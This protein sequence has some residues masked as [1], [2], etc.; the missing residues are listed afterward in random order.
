M[1]VKPQPHQVAA[2]I[3]DADVEQRIVMMV[4]PVQ[5]EQQRT[6]RCG[7]KSQ[8]LHV[9]LYQLKIFHAVEKREAAQAEGKCHYPV[10]V[11][12][13]ARRMALTTNRQQQDNQYRQRERGLQQEY[14]L[15][16][17][18]LYQCRS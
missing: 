16:V 14:S 15:P 18:S 13:R 2:T 3:D 17:P 6:G 5:C 11:T 1:T 7:K 12:Q 9:D 10:H 4:Q 8:L